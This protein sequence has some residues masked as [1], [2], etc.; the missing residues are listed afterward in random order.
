MMNNSSAPVCPICG[1]NQGRIAAGVAERWLVPAPGRVW[2]CPTCG[3][4]RVWPQSSFNENSERFEDEAYYAKTVGV[5]REHFGRRA[6]FIRSLTSRK[7]FLDVGCGRGEMLIEAQA[8]GFE[9]DGIELSTYAASFGRET[10]KLRISNIPIQDVAAESYDVVHSSHVLEHVHDPV[11]FASHIKRALAPNG[12][13]VLEVPNEFMNLTTRLNDLAG[14][15]RKRVLPSIHLFYFAPI[16]LRRLMEKAGFETMQVFTYSHRLKTEST[17]F[18][19]EMDSG[20]RNML[21]NI[22]DTARQGD[23]IV[24]VGK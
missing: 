7:R 15:S 1:T 5:K 9:A 11:E 20:L 22:A 19:K 12:I 13:C 14:R 4:R 6:A 3:L 10:Y 23:N 21:R 16:T 24:Y 18:F 2:D 17:S 8:V